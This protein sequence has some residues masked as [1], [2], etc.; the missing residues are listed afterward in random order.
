MSPQA[1]NTSVSSKLQ[2]VFL[3]ACT[4]IFI[5]PQIIQ[6]FVFNQLPITGDLVH[7]RIVYLL[8]NFPNFENISILQEAGRPEM[9]HHAIA[10]FNIVTGLTSEKT[11][12]G[13]GIMNFVGLGMALLIAWNFAKRMGPK[14]T[15]LAP[16]FMIA[17]P[18][19]IAPFM[20]QADIHLIFIFVGMSFLTMLFLRPTPWAHVALLIL[21][22]GGVNSHFMAWLPIFLGL[23]LMEM[24]Y[25][26]FK[27]LPL[28]PFGI[29]LS[30]YLIKYPL[31]YLSSMNTDIL[32]WGIVLSCFGALLFYFIRHSFPKVSRPLLI[33]CGVAGVLVFMLPQEGDP[34]YLTLDIS[35]VEEAAATFKHV[36][37]WNFLFWI[38]PAKKIPGEFMYSIL[39]LISMIAVITVWIKKRKEK[40]ER[41]IDK[42]LNALFFL[43]L[44]PFGLIILQFVLL[45]INYRLFIL[46]PLG[47]LQGGRIIIISFFL[48][49]LAFIYALNFFKGKWIKSSLMALVIISVINAANSSQFYFF[50]IA[51]TSQND[52][53]EAFQKNLEEGNEKGLSGTDAQYSCYAYK[54]CNLKT[55]D[56]FSW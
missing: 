31:G 56:N 20:G 33:F 49:I 5:V 3:S 4:G 28:F 32:F 39:F 40:F 46:S 12:Y 15:F 2:I 26:R 38:N 34:V 45:K 50:R 55:S 19:L 6:Q 22:I 1:P 54:H 30:W 11:F 13:F 53:Q 42:R 41:E 52:Y 17:T 14:Y 21:L 18:K 29:I 16:L 8:S 7:K 24:V 10:F 35:K 48:G 47:A 27:A 37:F 36:N 25:P 44:I 43:I 9:Y 23:I 51:S